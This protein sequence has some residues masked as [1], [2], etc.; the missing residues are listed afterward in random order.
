MTNQGEAVREIVALS[1]GRLIGKTRLQ[2][3]GYLLELAGLG[4]GFD[5]SYRRQRLVGELQVQHL[6]RLISFRGRRLRS[7]VRRG[8]R[9]IIVDR[10]PPARSPLLTPGGFL[11]AAPQYASTN[12]VSLSGM[13]STWPALAMAAW[14]SGRAR[15]AW[16]RA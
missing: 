6:R 13:R 14:T 16:K 2:K 3:A 11:D 9:Q 5:F 8:V 1:G 4:Y 15:T 7:G 12:V 10:W